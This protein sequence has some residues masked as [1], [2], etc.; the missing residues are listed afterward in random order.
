MK[1]LLILIVFLLS[2]TGFVSAQPPETEKSSQ[3]GVGLGYSF[4]G[5]REETVLPLGRYHNTLTFIINGNIEKG[6]FLN[7]FNLGFFRGKDAINA[8]P[9]N[10]YDRQPDVISPYFEFYQ[11]ENTFTRVYLEYALDYRLWGNQTF[12]GY[13]GGAIRGDV[14]AI[15]TLNNILYLNYT[16]LVS[17]NL[18][19]S[20]KWII[21]PKNNLLF[22]VSFPIVGYAVRPSFIGFSSWPLETGIVSLHNY[23]AVFGDLKYHHKFNSLISVQTGLGFELSHIVFPR[24]RKDAAFRLNAGVAFTF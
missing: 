14:Y 7:S 11:I 23:R 12:P 13:L 21:N 1:R 20:Q 3:V 6:S 2:I 18:H 17:F 22:S 15:E 24:P 10:E 9:R 19:A 16:G 4:T 8:Q 5:Y